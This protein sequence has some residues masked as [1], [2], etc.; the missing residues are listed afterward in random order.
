MSHVKAVL[1]PGDLCLACEG[2]VPQCGV[3]ARPRGAGVNGCS[4]AEASIVA[5]PAVP[6]VLHMSL[7]DQGL[8]PHEIDAPSRLFLAHDCH[9]YA[10]ASDPFQ[11]RGDLSAF[12]FLAA[13][14]LGL[15]LCGADRGGHA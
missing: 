4:L 15:I 13:F 10:K 8:V 9:V 12:G 5:Y 6:A 14:I 11:D 1:A 2:Y 7:H 3:D